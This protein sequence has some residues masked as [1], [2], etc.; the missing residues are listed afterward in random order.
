MFDTHAHYNNQ[1]FESETPSGTLMLLKE[2]S[3]KGVTGIVNASWDI[4]SSLDS[5]A[6]AK[7]LPFV[8]ASAG[9]HPSDA[10]HSPPLNAAMDALSKIL[11]NKEKNKVVAIGEI[12][13]DYYYEDTDKTVQRE[14]LYAQLDLAKGYKMPV[15]IHDRDA[16][17][18]I[19]A[20]VKEN[21]FVTGVFH[22]FSGS[23]ETARELA[24]LGWY[25]S[26]SGTLTFKN[27][28]K[29]KEAALAVP[30]ENILV[31]TDCPYLAPHPHRGELNHSGL[32]R[33]TIAELAALR[34]ISFEEAE[35]ITETNA[36]RLFGIEEPCKA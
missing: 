16:H 12:G 3:D 6:L 9:I 1:R 27:A 19:L 30:L 20:A 5:V 24:C 8:W 17:G 34:G 14:Y 11:D 28:R 2:L 26:F 13:L 31:E 35:A 15:I 36:R 7:R 23:A 25:I 10:K 29:V 21:P 18:D 33:Y 4:E 32:M 22:S